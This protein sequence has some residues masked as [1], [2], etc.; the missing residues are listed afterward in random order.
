MSVASSSDDTKELENSIIEWQAN[1]TDS[2]EQHIP[3]AALRYD[4]I[5]QL[6][7]PALKL[8]R[9]EKEG[10]HGVNQRRLKR[11]LETLLLWGQQ[12]KVSTGELDRLIDQSWRLRQCV[13][14]KLTSIGQALTDR[15]FYSSSTKFPIIAD[16]VV[17]LI[18]RITKPSPEL[19]QKHVS[20]LQKAGEEAA[21]FLTGN[22]EHEHNGNESSDDD[23]DIS[24]VFQADSLSE[25]TEDMTSYV[26]N[27]MELDALYDAAQENVNRH[28]IEPV[29]KVTATATPIDPSS[30]AKVY[31]EMIRKRFPD[32]DQELLNYLGQGNY[33]RIVKG[34]EQRNKK[35]EGQ[36]EDASGAKDHDTAPTEGSGFYYS[37]VSKY[38]KW[39]MRSRLPEGFDI[40]IP[41]LPEE[42]KQ[43]QPFLCIACGRKVLIRSTR[44]WRRHL[45]SDLDSY[46]C[47]EISCKS[48]LGPLGGREDWV[49]HL[50]EH[51]GDKWQ[52]IQCSLCLEDTG[53]G[54]ANVTGHLEKHLQSIALAALPN[55]W[56]DRSE[57]ESDV[58]NDDDD[59]DDDDE[60]LPR[61]ISSVSKPSLRRDAKSQNRIKP[62]KLAEAT[63]ER[64]SAKLL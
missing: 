1:V 4:L 2:P 31:T 45:F 49:K 16:I 27:L 15:L 46:T 20:M 42:G 38:Q 53:Q 59:D 28:S 19:L 40:K 41:L 63:E 60:T 54:E 35:H 3:L 8:L 44:A 24:S 62:M 30:A 5:V 39:N 55:D 10:D 12:Y 6:Y 34:L 32:I 17:G 36:V 47:L 13:L 26:D 50:T 33:F 23:S 21:F 14:G 61:W 48:V 58:E 43:G 22:L 37:G 18:P 7:K 57:P 51:Y 9:D 56:G 25:I 29:A 64:Q 52:S 11:A